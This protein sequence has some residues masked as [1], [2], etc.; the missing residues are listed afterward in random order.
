MVIGD[1]NIECIP[2]L[3][4]KTNAPLI[5]DSDCVLTFPVSLTLVKLV[6]GW[7]L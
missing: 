5:V 4:T 2:I 7:R 3:K 6:S 1:L